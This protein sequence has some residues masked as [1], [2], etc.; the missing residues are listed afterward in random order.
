MDDCDNTGLFPLDDPNTNAPVG[1]GWTLLA[2][3]LAALFPNKGGAVVPPNIGA[4][5]DVSCDGSMV[6]FG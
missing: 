1:A 3:I 6:L 2:T 4:M 5:E